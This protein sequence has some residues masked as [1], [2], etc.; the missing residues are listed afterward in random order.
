MNATDI[1][2]ALRCSATALG[3]GDCEK[4]AYYYRDEPSPEIAE[5]YGDVPDNFWE[6]CDCDR[7]ARDAADL[8]ERQERAIERLKKEAGIGGT[9]HF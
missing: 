5:E 3:T 4:C 1:I 9:D 2:K 7:V 6:S 8:I